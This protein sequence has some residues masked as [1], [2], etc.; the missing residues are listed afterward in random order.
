MNQFDKPIE[1]KDLICDCGSIMGSMDKKSKSILHINNGVKILKHRYPEK[2]TVLKCPECEGIV[3][4]IDI[5]FEDFL[6]PQ[7]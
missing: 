4:W 1:Q 6:Y 2:R 7:I 3:V 5:T